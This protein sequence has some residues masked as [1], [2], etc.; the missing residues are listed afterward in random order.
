MSARED[1]LRHQLA[2][3]QDALQRL[4]NLTRG[5]LAGGRREHLLSS[6]AVRGLAHE[7]DTARGKAGE[8]EQL[9]APKPAPAPKLPG[10]GT[11]AWAVLEALEVDHRA[12]QQPHLA[13]LAGLTD[14][15]LAVRISGAGANS[16]RPRRIE[17]TRRG[18]VEQVPDTDP[19]LPARWRI[20]ALAHALL[21]PERTA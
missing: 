21:S 5:G 13:M 1:Q 15:Q 7:L 11:V 2:E 12:H 8:L 4:D 17:L 16:V 18:L 14:A 19:A 6:W 10:I 20:T 9:L 3:L